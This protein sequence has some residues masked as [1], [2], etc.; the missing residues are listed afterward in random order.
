MCKKAISVQCYYVLFT[1]LVMVYLVLRAWKVPLV[2]DE[3]ITFFNYISYGRLAP[4]ND[5]TDANHH[6]LNTWLSRLS[7]LL[8][9]GG[10]LAL[11]LPNLLFFPL[12]AFYAFR[13][14]QKTEDTMLRIAFL[15]MMLGSF[16][17]L[18][19]FAFTRGYGMSMALM[20]MFLSHSLDWMEAAKRRDFFLLLGALS[21]AL[22]ANLTLIPLMG[23]GLGILLLHTLVGQRRSLFLYLIPLGIMG[24]FAWLAFEYKEMGLLY[25]GSPD[26]SL[27]LMLETHLLMLFGTQAAWLKGVFLLALGMLL[28]LYLNVWRNEGFSSLTSARY[29]LAHLFFGVLAGIL[30]MHHFGGINYPED[31]TSLY[32]YPLGIIAGIALIAGFKGKAFP[33]M[34]MSASLMALGILVHGLSHI[35]LRMAACWPN[36][37]VPARFFERMEAE[38]KAQE[39]PYTL[40]AHRLRSV[41]W[42]Y[43]NF[44]RQGGMPYA[45]FTQHPDTFA[46]YQLINRDKYPGWDRLY[47]ILEEEPANQSLLVR[48]KKPLVRIPETAIIQR[49]TE[50]TLRSEF[51]NL[52]DP[53]RS[54]P[55]PPGS[56]VVQIGLVV[57]SPAVPFEA[58]LVAT[59]ADTAGSTL[60]Y[61]ATKLD[62]VARRWEKDT[63][64]TSMLLRVE[65]GREAY[66][67]S[68]LWNLRQQP[69]FIHEARV[70]WL[71]LGVQEE[72]NPDF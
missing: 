56:Y 16:F 57:S 25:Y 20:L 3:V 9:G 18:E 30:G 48:R 21:L 26:N 37:L 40:S 49:S 39:W 43:Y 65:E 13:L 64:R 2:H 46:D 5:Y 70:Q 19:F 22:L 11:R 35:N 45:H 6:L 52:Q 62:W 60:A 8:F 42:A 12:Y 72:K 29:F 71:R 24:A 51:F 32:L 31:R 59:T 61:E 44:D 67:M 47:E 10:P 53:D 34:R 58:W 55:L 27:M 23:L 63:L 33:A 1:T 36:E 54:K 41:V 4:F 69:F 14:S 28:V 17:F 7:F 38:S 66:G 15:L 50:D 68:Y